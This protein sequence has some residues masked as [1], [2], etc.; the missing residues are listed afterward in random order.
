MPEPIYLK[1]RECAVLL[2]VTTAYIVGEIKDGRLP[3]R[4]RTTPDGR[5]RYRVCVDDWRLYIARHWPLKV[6]S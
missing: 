6:A 2:G 3:A 4:V 1:T 5:I